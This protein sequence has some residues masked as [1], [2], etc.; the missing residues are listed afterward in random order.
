MKRLFTTLAVGLMSSEQRIVA[1]AADQA[2][3]GEDGRSWLERHRRDQRHTG[4]LLDGMGYKAKVD[5]LAVP[6]AYGGLK[7]GQVDVFLGNWMPAQQGFYDKFI[8]T[9]MSRNWRRTWK[10][11]SSPSPC[12]ITS[13]T[14][15]CIP[16]PT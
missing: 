1:Y 9:A 7:D 6:I 4:L 10:A 2:A 11:P 14:R 13:T 16:S 15:V 8:A 5:T 12:R 3:D